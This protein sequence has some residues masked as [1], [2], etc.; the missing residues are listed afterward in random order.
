MLCCK[1]LCSPSLTCYVAADWCNAS[2]ALASMPPTIV[3]LVRSVAIVSRHSKYGRPNGD[4]SCSA[5]YT[6]VL[7]R[8]CSMIIT[9]LALLH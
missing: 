5:T 4:D 8:S 3:M 7:R 1:F 2:Q 9:S 6:T